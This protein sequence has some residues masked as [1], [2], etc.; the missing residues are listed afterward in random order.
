MDERTEIRQFIEELLR[1]KSDNAPFSDS[2]SLTL[3]GR[4]ESIETVEIVMFLE[5][6]FGVDFSKIG[7]DQDQMDS[8]DL[9]CELV[10]AHGV[11]PGP[12]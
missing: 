8:I 2:E 1:K 11:K 6:H 9:I 7:F 10:Q 4:L 12:A 3:S 5:S